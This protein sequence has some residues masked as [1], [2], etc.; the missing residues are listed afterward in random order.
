MRGI[1]I[2][3]LVVSVILSTVM[4]VNGSF[5]ASASTEKVKAGAQAIKQGHYEEALKLFESALVQA[6]D[7]PERA[8]AHY[9]IGKTYNRLGKYGL[10]LENLQ[11]SG[12]ILERLDDAQ[13]ELGWAY[14]GLRMFDKAVGPLE[15][16]ERKEP[17]RGQTSL[18]LG[19][20]YLG[21]GKREEA[22][23]H[24]R[25]AVR[26]NPGLAGT[27]EFYLAQIAYLRGE[28]ESAAAG[29]LGLVREHPD[30]P[31][32]MRVDELL[33]EARKEPFLAKPWDLFFSIGAGY[34][35]NVLGKN[36]DMP[37][38][39]G[40]SSESSA[41]L[42]LALHGRYSWILPNKDLLTAGY[43]FSADTYEHA[44]NDFNAMYHYGYVKHHRAWNEKVM[45]GILISNYLTV[46]GGNAYHNTISVRPS[47]TFVETDWTW[48][49]V[50]YRYSDENRMLSTTPTYNLDGYT[51]SIGLTKFFTIP[52]L[53]TNFRIGYFHVWDERDSADFDLRADQV[54]AGIQH[55][56]P[57]K[58]T[59]DL[60]YMHAFNR[61]TELST[62][63]QSQKKR[64]DDIDYVDLTFTRPLTEHL[65]VYCKFGYTNDN[66]NITVFEYSNYRATAGLA[67]SF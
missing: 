63:A 43:R 12:G 5:A 54:F 23:K 18:F 8:R 59:V 47:F 20:A 55:T 40:I 33:K 16:Y 21:L 22:E 62:F 28:K 27:A 44:L 65:S 64:S 17:G 67:W 11:R 10:A 37:R 52:R 36:S 38:P 39:E 58:I 30:S 41:V 45:T 25:E 15:S 42:E 26:R 2:L 19:R 9:M 60:L 46:L 6:A 48:T 50:A 51:H 61:Y 34:E 31:I 32:A 53:K 13:F 1:C 35:D 14:V 4:G 7:R 3:L 29:L 66:S 24:L 49:E 56:F 57:F